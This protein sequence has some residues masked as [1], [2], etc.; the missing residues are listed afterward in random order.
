MIR[1]RYKVAKY[2]NTIEF[3]LKTNVDLR[4]LNKL[5]SSLT[6]VQTSF[7]Q[8]SFGKKG[9]LSTFDDAISKAQDLQKVLNEAF[10]TGIG[11]FDAKK[12]LSGI[13]SVY[14]SMSNF[15]AEMKKAGASGQQAFNNIV[16]SVGKLN[17]ALKTTTNLADKIFNTI[18]NTVRWGIIS[19]AFESMRNEI[20]RAIQY[21]QDLDR[22]L[23]DIRIVSGQ[24]ADQMRRFAK[25]ANEAAKNLGKTTTSFTDAALIFVQQGYDS[26]K[27]SELAGL[28]L[29]TA[30]VTGQSTSEVSEQLTALINGYQLQ[31][32]SIEYVEQ[33]VDKL[34]K[35][36]AV[37]AADLEELATGFSKVSA[38]A[39]MLGVSTD[40]LTAQL[41]TIISVTREAPESVGNALKTI[42]SRLGD[43]KLGETLEDGMTL[44]RISQTLEKVGVE[45]LDTSGE[46]RNM[47]TIIEDLMGKWQGLTT[48]QREGAAQALA[49]RYQFTRLVALLDNS[50]MYYD[51]LGESMRSAGTL[52]EQQ[53][54]YMDSIHAKMNAM[55]AAGEGLIN[56]LFDVDT[57]KPVLDAVTDLV[58]GVQKFVDVI[59]GGQTVI[60]AFGAALAN[61]FSKNIA[62][63][64][65]TT[66]NNAQNSMMAVASSRQAA[67]Q[68]LVAMG[69]NSSVGGENEQQLINAVQ[70]RRQ[71][72]SVMTKQQMEAS[73]ASL[74][75]QVDTLNNLAAAQEKV[76][77]TITSYNLASQKA[78]G[79][80]A[81]FGEDLL[82]VNDDLTLTTERFTAATTASQ[83]M[84]TSFK[85]MR[86]VKFDDEIKSINLLEEG[87]GRVNT[88]FKN[89]GSGANLSGL[90][91][92]IDS[93][94]N[95]VS[96]L[97]M[98]ETSGAVLMPMTEDQM[99]R[100][101][102]WQS[103]IVEISNMTDSQLGSSHE[104]VNALIQEGIQLLGEQRTAYSNT[105]KYSEKDL[106][107]VAGQLE[108]LQQLQRQ[109]LNQLEQEALMRR[110]L[111]AQS[112]VTGITE[113]VSALSMIASFLSSIKNVIGIVIDEN[114]SFGEKVGNVF[115]NLSFTLPM[116]VM[117]ITS[118]V[119]GMKALRAA[120]Q[121]ED[122]TNY[123][124]MLYTS[125]VN[126]DESLTRFTNNSK[127]DFKTLKGYIVQTFTSV[128]QQSIGAM[129]S[130]GAQ[131][132]GFVSRAKIGFATMQA[133][134]KAAFTGLKL[135]A[136]S[137]GA[138]IQ[139]A[140][141]IIGWASMIISVVGM[142]AS[143]VSGHFDE[144][145]RKEE[146][147]V[148][149]V[150]QKGEEARQKLD[151]I[152]SAEQHFDE[153]YTKFQNDGLITEDLR[154]ALINYG[155]TLGYTIQAEEL[156][157]GSIQGVID[158]LNEYNRVQS[159]IA[160]MEMENAASAAYTRLTTGD[161]VV[162][163]NGVFSQPSSY[164]D[165]RDVIIQ[166][167]YMGANNDTHSGN[168]IIGWLVSD[169]KIDDLSNLGSITDE[170]V[171]GWIHTINM[172]FTE[173]YDN[174]VGF[175]DLKS[176]EQWAIVA[177]YIRDNNIMNEESHEESLAAISGLDLSQ[178]QTGN[179][180]SA[181]P[182]RYVPYLTT[183][184]DVYDWLVGQGYMQEGQH[185][186]TLP[187]ADRFT[188][189]DP[190]SG[191]IIQ[192]ASEE[193]IISQ[194]TEL[195]DYYTQVLYDLYQ[196][197][198]LLQQQGLNTDFIDSYIGQVQEAQKTL[199]GL[200]SDVSTIQQ[201]QQ[202]SANYNASRIIESISQN[203]VEQGQEINEEAVR[204]LFENDKVL[205]YIESQGYSAG[206]LWVQ[207]YVSGLGESYDA[208]LVEAAFLQQARERGIATPIDD[209]AAGWDTKAREIG[210][211]GTAAAE[212]FTRYDENQNAWAKP[213]RQALSAVG[214]I[215]G[216]TEIGAY[217]FVDTLGR[218]GIE[219]ND[220]ISAAAEIVEN[221]GEDVLKEF[222][223][224]EN[225]LLL[226][227]NKS[228]DKAEERSEFI[229]NAVREQTKQGYLPQ[230]EEALQRRDT[231]GLTADRS[232]EA[233]RILDQVFDQLAWDATD[234]ER[235]EILGAWLEN[236]ALDINK[237]IKAY[238]NGIGDI[239]VAA[240]DATRALI[241]SLLDS[242][243][244][245]SDVEYIDEGWEGRPVTF[246]RQGTATD[247]LTI[248]QDITEGD[249]QLYQELLTFFANYKGT[250]DL[251]ALSRMTQDEARGI[252]TG[253]VAGWTTDTSRYSS[254]EQY[255]N[256]QSI[257]NDISNAALSSGGTSVDFGK[258]E[259]FVVSVA[260]NAYDF[261]NFLSNL[262]ETDYNFSAASTEDVERMYFTHNIAPDFVRSNFEG[263]NEEIYNQMIDSLMQQYANAVANGTEES[264][265]FDAYLGYM[266]S[267]IEVMS[268][269]EGG[270]DP[271][272]QAMIL[273]KA[274]GDARKAILLAQK[275][276]TDG[277]TAIQLAYSTVTWEGD[278]PTIKVQEE[279]AQWQSVKTAEFTDQGIT[280]RLAVSEAASLVTQYGL[281]V[282]YLD[283]HYDENIIKNDFIKGIKDYLLTKAEETADNFNREI[284]YG[285][286]TLMTAYW[287]AYEDF[288]EEGYTAEQSAKYAGTR[289]AT[290]QGHIAA[291]NL[292]SVSD[293]IYGIA[294]R[295]AAEQYSL[296]SL[297]NTNGNEI[298]ASQFAAF[299]Q[300]FKGDWADWEN[301][302]KPAFERF[303]V[304]LESFGDASTDTIV[305][306]ENL[307]SSLAMA[308]DEETAAEAVKTFK[309][310]IDALNL[311]VEATDQ[312]IAQ[313]ASSGNML[314]LQQANAMFA[315]L[316]E[317]GRNEAAYQAVA[318]MSVDFSSE[319]LEHDV[320]AVYDEAAELFSKVPQSMWPTMIA[321]IDFK[322]DPNSQKPIEQQ[323]QDYFEETFSDEVLTK[324]TEDYTAIAR[325]DA[326]MQ[327]AGIDVYGV[328]NYITLM[329]NFGKEI[330]DVVAPGFYDLYDATA[331]AEE[332]IYRVSVAALGLSQ[333]FQ[334]LDKQTG[335][336]LT[337][338]GYQERTAALAL[339]E[340]GTG[341]YYERYQQYYRDNMG[342]MFQAQNI[343]SFEDWLDETLAQELNETARLLRVGGFTES[344]RQRVT[345]LDNVDLSEMN[346]LLREANNAGVATE[347]FVT[348]LE[349]FSDQVGKNDD[350]IIELGQAM[351]S[352]STEF[353]YVD[354]SVR[355][356]LVNGI[357]Q[358][359]R[360]L[361]DA[362]ENTL[363]LQVATAMAADQARAA[364]Q[365]LAGYSAAMQR[366]MIELVNIEGNQDWLDDLRLLAEKNISET[367]LSAISP[368]IDWTADGDKLSNQI[369]LLTA[370]FN[371]LGNTVD[372]ID[373]TMQTT[374]FDSVM[375]LAGK[376]KAADPQLSMDKAIGQ[377]LQMYRTGISELME[378]GYSANGASTIA[379]NI[380][381]RAPSENAAKTTSSFADAM[382]SAGYSEAT[383]V[384][385]S[386]SLIFNEESFDLDEDTRA[387]AQRVE[388]AFAT[389]PE[390]DRP[391]IMVG[392]TF[393][394]NATEEYITQQVQ[395][396]EMRLVQERRKTLGYESYDVDA[397][398]AQAEAAG[399]YTSDSS[400]EKIYN[401]EVMQILEDANNGLI[402]IASVLPRMTAL[403]HGWSES[404][405][406]LGVSA[407]TTLV[408]ILAT[409][410]QIPGVSKEA[411]NSMLS[412]FSES[413]AGLNLTAEQEA[414]A[415]KSFKSIV[416]TGN[417]SAV[418]A[419]ASATKQASVAG[420][421]GAA[422]DYMIQ[423]ANFT[424]S[425]K[426]PDEIVSD[427]L[428]L[429]ERA[430]E[431]L[432]KHPLSILAQLDMSYSLEEIDRQAQVLE[433]K[434]SDLYMRKRED[435][436]SRGYSTSDM[437]TFI[438]KAT[439]LG[440]AADEALEMYDTSKDLEGNMY[441]LE[442]SIYSVN[443]A[444]R[445]LSL[446]TQV[447]L[448]GAL[449]ELQRQSGLS[450][451]DT[452]RYGNRLATQLESRN[453][454]MAQ[455]EEVVATVVA[456]PTSI[457]KVVEL[458]EGQLADADDAITLAVL[459][460]FD[461][462]KD[463]EN[464][465][466]V[467]VAWAN[468]LAAALERVPKDKW[469]DAIASM[470]LEHP[471]QWDKEIDE[472][473]ESIKEQVEDFDFG[474]FNIEVKVNL[475]GDKEIVNQAK[476]LKQLYEEVVEAYNT[477]D[478]FNAGGF[479]EDEV[480][481][482]VAEN[483]ELAD[484][485]VRV[486]DTWQLSRRFMSEQQG[487]IEG[488]TA[489]LERMLGV[490]VD[491]EV[492]ISK[493]IQI[494]QAYG[495]VLSDTAN[496]AIQQLLETMRMGLDGLEDT[497]EALSAYLTR[498][499]Q[500]YTAFLTS[501]TN[502]VDLATTSISELLSKSPE[503]Y[504][505]VIVMT[506]QLAQGISALTREYKNGQI[507]IGE[508]SEGLIQSTRQTVKA[509]AATYQLKEGTDG[510]YEITRD[511]TD[512]QIEAAQSCNRLVDEIETLESSLAFSEY[513]TE[514]FDALDEVFTN[515]FGIE[516]SAKVV[517]DGITGIAD[518]YAGLVYG[519]ADPIQDFYSENTDLLNAVAATLEQTTG[520]AADEIVGL[521]MGGAETT[522]QLGALMVQNAEVAGG[523]ASNVA[524]GTSL[525]IQNISSGIMDFIDAML[526]YIGAASADMGL[527]VEPQEDMVQEITVSNADGGEVQTLGSIQIPQ[528]KMHLN[529]NTSSGNKPSGASTYRDTTTG[530]W[531]TSY[532]ESYLTSETRPSTSNS[533]ILRQQA[534]RTIT[535][536]ATDS[537]V[538][539]AVRGEAR[540]NAESALN[541]VGEGIAGLFG[542]LFSAYAPSRGDNNTVAP[543]YTPKDSGGGGGGGKGGSGSGSEPKLDVMEPVEDEKDL[544]ERVNTLLD[545]VKNDLEEISEEQDRLIGD[546]LTQNM[547]D[548]INLLKIEI[549]LHEKKLEIQQQEAA[550]V[551]DELASL[552]GVEFD[553]RG[554][555]TNYAAVFD[556]KL[557]DINNL[558]D[559]YNSA[560]TEE[561]QDALKEQIEAAQ[562]A[563]DDF[564]DGIE[565]YDTLVGDEM[566]QTRNEIEKL[567]NEIED[568]Q[569]EA[570][571]TA[572]EAIDNVK[573][574]NEAA[575]D[576]NHVF[577]GEGTD[578]PF[579][580]TS[581]DIQKL[582]KYFDDA[583][584][585][586]DDYYD[587][588]MRVAQE[589]EAAAQT[590]KE[591][592][593]YQ[594]KQQVIQAARDRVEADR[595][596][597]LLF[598][599]NGTGYLDMRQYMMNAINDMIEQYNATGYTD[600][601]GEDSADLY[602]V[603][604]DIMK[605]AQDELA[606]VEKQ[607]E[608]VV[609]DIVKDIDKIGDKMKERLSD[610]ERVGAELD[611]MLTV[612]G[613]TNGDKAYEQQTQ[614]YNEMLNNNQAQI[615]TLNFY[616]D[617]WRDMLG[618]FQE[619]SDQWK[620][621][622]DKLIDATEKLRKVEEN[623]IKTLQERRNAETGSVLNTLMSTIG[624]S[625]DANGNIINEGGLRAITY[626][627]QTGEREIYGTD[628][629]D[630]VKQQWELINRNAD[631]Y[632]DDVNRAAELEKLQYK[633]L[634]LL[635]DAND[636]AI[637]RE[638]SD[639][640][641]QQLGYLREKTALS[642]YDM[643][644]ANAQLDILQKQ[645][646]LEE[647]Q[648]NKSQLKLRRD[649]Q[650]NY[651]YV[652]TANRGD[653]ASAQ[654]DLV[655]ARQNAYNLA[656]DHSV[657]MQGQ[658]LEALASFRQAIF[659]T[660]K[661][662]NL[663]AEEQANRFRFLAQ[664]LRDY[665]TGNFEQ[666]DKAT[667]DAFQEAIELAD[668][669]ALENAADLQGLFED[670]QNGTYE[671]FDAIDERYH[672][673]FGSWLTD[674]NEY[675]ET[676]DTTTDGLIDVAYEY[677]DALADTAES[678]R[679]SYAD[680]T[681]AINDTAL[682]TADLNDQA[683][684]FNNLMLEL[685][686]TVGQYEGNLASLQARITDN[687]NEM[688]RYRD[689]V[690]E[691][692][693]KLGAAERD[694]AMMSSQ[695]SA[696]TGGSLGGG[697]SGAFGPGNGGYTGNVAKYASGSGTNANGTHFT[698]QELIEGIAGNIWTYGSWANDPTRHRD[699]AA[700]FGSEMAV[701]IQQFV[702]RGMGA[703]AHDW[704]SGYY[705]QFGMSAFDTGGYTGDW[706]GDGRIAMLHQ[707]ELVLN[708]DDTSNILEAV[709]TMRDIQQANMLDAINGAGAILRTSFGN[710]SMSEME[711]NV[712]IEAT[713]PGVRTAVEIE[714]ALLG[715]TERAS[716][717][718][719]RQDR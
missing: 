93:L 544:Y 690:N 291:G 613:L 467:A 357:A 186:F 679:S 517:R 454:S 182:H 714:Q 469:S 313:L 443:G 663:A 236:D 589:Q 294:S 666:M 133:S 688:A 344:Q 139:S 501:L 79:V 3:N 222:L 340:E 608:A 226:L 492:G 551:A 174:V 535:R 580:K 110:Q 676:V 645:I 464:W 702:E 356:S 479:N 233:Q 216:Q 585:S 546:E 311:S 393:D 386:A 63:M 618:M 634:E 351:S 115:E 624:R 468:G 47:G 427:A 336:N 675:S 692:N 706:G 278:N 108:Y 297:F 324:M 299:N 147:R 326:A 9:N 309:H 474:D 85:Q 249:E 143:A 11:G 269:I 694:K 494:Q 31:G 366:K 636:P 491:T 230:V 111:A 420:M 67:K 315:H 137:L 687:E 506:E 381:T 234:E 493:L 150:I 239:Y 193:D 576:F 596:N 658:S 329:H 177:Q 60:T 480:A 389:I 471:D 83:T 12:V 345:S 242:N 349:T 39:N 334:G 513:I 450:P 170:V 652:Y 175:K 437:D 465:E 301:G 78:K 562:D 5:Q 683:T 34:A 151:S 284:L 119:N 511:M 370:V 400:G 448:M 368:F 545:A 173:F 254:A 686:G 348:A 594:K 712:H 277:I 438:E 547:A 167:Q 43:V 507:T 73:N 367:T 392:L 325:R 473:L 446:T 331:S 279:L 322:I 120:K 293:T 207:G 157:I 132:T 218:V 584:E 568:L 583:A 614:L 500:D 81:E 285:N 391:T 540:S 429:G 441:A 142:V 593:F 485:F 512:A 379:T 214:D 271:E 134:G 330:E 178:L 264:F 188:A 343:M 502:G 532:D 195:N 104:K 655:E 374:L 452:E 126:S 701:A 459:T 273:E 156:R 563:F 225:G 202:S 670:L 107:A 50:A 282:D 131:T 171:S 310:N 510:Y 716:Q 425:E 145:Q 705:Q 213:Y 327:S 129:T 350:A 433:A 644:Y 698:D 320:E 372:G 638:I 54:V 97:M 208:D 640:M 240:D 255:A 421:S 232:E 105:C 127:M 276:A 192:G 179:Y 95:S 520:V 533:G 359:A 164:D 548:Q 165:P 639:Q 25:E 573:K 523:L 321:M 4:A 598:G 414:N 571:K 664:S 704:S 566:R 609:D 261:Y 152:V 611:H 539:E 696:L 603:A 219:Y 61:A 384:V 72:S 541:R 347:Y 534:T 586:A 82:I 32:A 416:E 221:Y 674:F 542:D 201:A 402:P 56:S 70:M 697:T 622:N 665:L 504:D 439:R 270:E 21:V 581:A 369:N 410:E 206:S 633:Y 552:Y 478:V 626:N 457:P 259:D 612:S 128:K 526:T 200:G 158:K 123:F 482:Y 672:S 71:Y 160:Q 699:L 553:D 125:I 558:I 371:A 35:V 395:I 241:D 130:A 250:I 10:N 383:A 590:D 574:L 353:W 361:V 185:T 267:F 318:V 628:D 677:A 275:A 668:M 84:A 399:L 519:L 136:V 90:R 648:R 606:N 530:Q 98:D 290:L 337:N 121:S 487:A 251:N 671:N 362:S 238:Y 112:M 287:E 516:E 605:N 64:L 18:G 388:N 396:A 592:E 263:M 378:M 616:I 77:K 537:E 30:N 604:E 647:A 447:S 711:Q 41:S 140:L 451:E 166:S 229:T 555:I 419:F 19:G 536:A 496:I 20:G 684:G 323:I 691:L 495:D 52:E 2:G 415:A 49:G 23:N 258:L 442:S 248:L 91:T 1:R 659:D 17:I 641:A 630:W 246:H 16:G 87:L 333:T 189:F 146:E 169:F 252:L 302:V 203:G 461:Q 124:R 38:V 642:Q 385:L 661:N 625:I 514:N 62:S 99:V 228:E 292:G 65:V 116:I 335:Y 57:V 319:T 708:K 346:N 196:Q 629:L 475:T 623:R 682:A 42:Y 673:S 244:Q 44:G 307:R 477:E 397:A 627:P 509:K 365:A 455:T 118:M 377:A 654:N 272:R 527:S 680:M 394:E 597:G 314:A 113:Y 149:A 176:E 33:Q 40:Q 109:R 197:Q 567:K 317:T 280:P 531:V 69:L 338:R 490:T 617:Y 352:V 637:Q 602:E 428:E 29:K 635:N 434:E 6:K 217:N 373:S 713:F 403:T 515:G 102:S 472:F 710:T 58:S 424:D 66:V 376:L 528:F 560:T 656:K 260:G 262:K 577:T 181:A 154:Q 565:R 26:K 600:V 404:F 413:L 198:H 572:E 103:K 632:L 161:N 22:S 463:A 8:L 601:F 88:E 470:D 709:R 209:V 550:A 24:S 135:G 703:L 408:G 503:M 646:A 117:G 286:T 220:F 304:T 458:L 431:V 305:N 440:I 621:A 518:E 508:Y 575:I 183:E 390:E 86:A 355:T 68:D 669:L 657:D 476:T 36:A 444:F 662:D 332:M 619:G 417:I 194:Y 215:Y 227:V 76:N 289:I 303:K 445:Q 700:K 328:E 407:Q 497:P 257:I 37:G 462:F 569:I 591:R 148:D 153:L 449:A 7:Q 51:Q 406:E 163:S 557:A 266:N 430:Q 559:K 488:Q 456:D 162:S 398:L 435:I 422:Y 180:G 245:L 283:E 360:N 205:S 89:L 718:I 481:A 587:S 426:D 649:A 211:S 554:F 190:F 28:T 387:F 339:A 489:A 48:A 689:L 610:Y 582:A 650:G 411:A 363:D 380:L 436:E 138:A 561:E 432:D 693:D 484:A 341:K 354:A 53:A 486:G 409:L 114:K 595:A 401:R 296:N 685:S 247:L 288:I 256:I 253:K 643:E 298:T 382:K 549:G 538:S 719:W 199:Q 92:E 556:Q 144:L 579:R 15:H 483:E 46:M 59:G 300:I 306:I 191:K 159:Q 466:E 187:G 101:N 615:D 631:Q 281:G 578:D 342:D 96:T 223:K 423:H 106:Q 27:A 75:K 210:L 212:F 316:A 599:E 268:G 667:Q 695:L 155:E 529:A 460:H 521:V 678:V 237:L 45:V 172:F 295:G 651:S 412:A 235:M 204:Q 620:A 358:Y 505:L 607:I 265:D 660:M 653:I 312:L 141:P 122:L 588:L 308:T 375:I 570:F 499:G 14:G 364:G 564:K 681:D 525:A 231:S 243:A 274:G 13:N 405:N 418:A 100:L 707:K 498:L 168:D 55:K 717:H 543:T 74:Q 453:F 94:R 522:E 524:S 224:S 80:T 184:A 715:L